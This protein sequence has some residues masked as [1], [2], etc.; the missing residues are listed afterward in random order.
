MTP[1]HVIYKTED[2]I[3][4]NYSFGIRWTLTVSILP[5][6]EYFLQTPYKCTLTESPKANL[7]QYN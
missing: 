5:V 7:L 2:K 4:R 3:N 6:E 1:T